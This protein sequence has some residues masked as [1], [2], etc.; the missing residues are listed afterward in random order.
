MQAVIEGA[1]GQAGRAF[2]RCSARSATAGPTRLVGRYAEQYRRYVAKGTDRADPP[3]VRG[4][5]R[6]GGRGR[7][8]GR[9]RFAPAP[10]Y[11]RRPDAIVRLQGKIDRI[12]LVEVDGKLGFRVIDYK[13]GS[14]PSGKDVQAGL[15]SQLPLYALAVEQLIFPGHDHEFADAGYWSMRKDGFRAVKLGKA[16][17]DYRESLVAFVVDLVARL[18]EGHFPI[19]SENKECHKYCDYH[20]ACRVKEVRYARKVWSGRPTLGSSPGNDE[21]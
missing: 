8:V 2:P 14:S 19:A 17:A 11:R 16:W 3:D 18:R 15:A 10:D 1:P 7:G 5:L 12:D 13:T 21:S 4:R 9:R 20:A 6:P